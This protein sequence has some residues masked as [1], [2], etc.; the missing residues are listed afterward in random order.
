MSYAH[1][2][3]PWGK[4]CQYHLLYGDQAGIEETLLGDCCGQFGGLEGQDV[5]HGSS[6]PQRRSGLCSFR[7][8]QVQGTRIIPLSTSREHDLGPMRQRMGLLP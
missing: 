6:K 2:T 3:E 1:Q 5:C 4:G 8:G 7:P